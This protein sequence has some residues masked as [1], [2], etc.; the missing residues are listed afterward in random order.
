[1][2]TNGTGEGEDPGDAHSIGRL[3]IG[4][5][6]SVIGDLVCAASLCVQKLAHNRIVAAGDKIKFIQ[7]PLWW[8]GMFLNISGEV[9]NL[10]AY[11]FAPAAVVAPVG[12][13]AVVGNTVFAYFFLKEPLSRREIIGTCIVL[14][15][16]VLVVVGA[17]DGDHG[18]D[19]LMDH[20]DIVRYINQ[21]AAYIYFII[22]V[23]LGIINLALSRKYGKKTVHCYALLGAN[24]GAYTVVFAKAVS[25]MMHQFAINAVTPT[26]WI[27]VTM[28]IFCAV[29]STKY[30]NDGMHY[31][32]NTVVIPIYYC[33]FTLASIVATSIIYREYEQMIM[34]LW[35]I[36]T[37]LCGLLLLLGG[38][39]LVQL[40]PSRRRGRRLSS[41]VQPR[42]VAPAP[43][44]NE[45]DEEEELEPTPLPL[46]PAPLPRPSVDEIGRIK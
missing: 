6:L 9:G 10:I 3:M 32:E 7:S 21:P 14:V 19:G 27:C 26:F 41:G 11:S 36:P 29:V 23:V 42:Y 31:F 13:V 40:T 34:Y 16:V 8:V 44:P 28:L 22:C 33:Y 39:W 5:T 2:G 20:E 46:P 35:K 24:I 12:A 4:V 45:G 38:V 25:T 37:F 17:P 18:G 43:N 30:L 1:M 15:G